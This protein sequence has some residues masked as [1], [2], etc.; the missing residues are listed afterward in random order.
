[1]KKTFSILLST[2]LIFSLTLTCFADTAANEVVE[3]AEEVYGAD[4]AGYLKALGVI[5]PDT[6]YSL[7]DKMTRGEFA[8]MAAIMG[9]Y[10]AGDATV[11]RFSDVTP[12][13]PYAAYINALASAKVV[14]GFSDGTYAPDKEITIGETVAVLNTILGYGAYAQAK[15]GYPSGHYYTA[16]RLDLFEYLD[17]ID[18]NKQATKGEVAQLCANALDAKTLNQVAFGEEPKF[19]TEDGV[20]LA[21][22]TFGIV[23][24]TGVV[25][26]VDISA[27]KGENHTTPWHMVVDDVK[28]EIGT[29]ADTWSYLGYEVDAYYVEGKRSA[30]EN[31]L[32][33]ISKTDYNEE[34]VIAIGDVVSIS[35]GRVEYYNADDKIDDV[36]Y[37]TVAAVV[38]NGA[39]TGEAFTMDMLKGY[40]GTVTI[41]DNSGDNYGDVIF[42]EAYHDIVAEIVNVNGEKLYDKY[43]P[44]RK[45]SVDTEADEP[46]TIVYNADGEE[47]TLSDIKEGNVVSVYKSK[48]DVDQELYK[49]YI[50]RDTAVGTIQEITTDSDR[51]YV[52][53]NETE[54]KITK[55]ATPYLKGKYKVGTNVTLR[56]NKFGEIADMVIGSDMLFGF[57]IGVDTGSGLSSQMQFKLY[58]DAGQFILPL[59]AN[60]IKVDNAA[61]T[62]GEASKLIAKLAAA[63]KVIYPDA[64]E[65]ITAQPVRFR[66]NGDGDI[67]TI[68]TIFADIEK[69]VLATKADAVGDNAL[70]QGPKGTGLRHRSSGGAEIFIDQSS[71]GSALIVTNPTTTKVIKYI[72]PE[73]GST[74]FFDEKNYSVIKMS[75]VPAGTEKEN[76]NDVKSFYSDADSEQASLILLNS[77]KQGTISIGTSLGVVASVSRVMYEDVACNKLVVQNNKGRST[78]YVKDDFT[79]TPA[80]VTDGDAEDFK[81]MTADSFKEGDVIKISTDTD[82]YATSIKLYYRIPE[83]RRV[84]TFENNTYDYQTASGLVYS[85]DSAA[86]RLLPTTNK[87]ALLTALPT[88]TIIF[89]SS[90]SCNYVLYDSAQPEGKRV[91]AGAYSDLLPYVKVGASETAYVLMQTYVCVPTFMIIVK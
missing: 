78:V 61:Y 85:K 76:L 21:K 65:G 14:S 32:K 46:Y 72:E 70:Y 82:G 73:A 35:D 20:T 54:Y 31:V 15:G 75:S 3:I 25:E 17:T 28:M 89:P 1:M 7:T 29:V 88:D 63:S 87:D 51:I 27:L 19:A 10:G 38:Y 71:F 47:G 37:R 86:F 49:L 42:V 56:L 22:Q 24:I 74:D 77:D 90:T 80:K 41:V 16:N 52:K 43:D 50:S 5:D 9:G 6:D 58:T 55:T 23:H 36:N 30:K 12:E 8:R 39:A 91:K 62:A 64:D 4:S 53:V 57:L 67:T 13:H 83:N 44:E 40:E 18:M 81:A 11:Q 84:E 60:K 69:E 48:A 68:D 45:I 79:Y 66:L 34:T 59:G 33:Y 2:I 26:A